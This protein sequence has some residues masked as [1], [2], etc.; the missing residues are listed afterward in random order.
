MSAQSH[1]K[2]FN[3][4]IAASKGQVL[5]DYPHELAND[6]LKVIDSD[7]HTKPRSRSSRT[8][9]NRGVDNLS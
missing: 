5:D 1:N 4:G 8:H 3:L 2:V 9:S 7:H 6:T